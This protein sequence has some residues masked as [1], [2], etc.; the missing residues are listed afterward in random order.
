MLLSPDEMPRPDR[1]LKT[2]RAVLKK[3]L[4]QGRTISP[5]LQALEHA[6]NQQFKCMLRNIELLIAGTK[7]IPVPEEPTL[8]AALEHTPRSSKS[9]KRRK[10]SKCIYCISLPLSHK[11]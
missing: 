5:T 6:A 8:G 4:D 3:A 10:R 7:F 1:D 2:M 11:L 9:S